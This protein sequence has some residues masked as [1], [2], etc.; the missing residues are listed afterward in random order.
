MTLS[1]QLSEDLTEHNIPIVPNIQYDI[2][3]MQYTFVGLHH[4]I[5]HAGASK[6]WKLIAYLSH[7][8]W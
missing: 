1:P 8:L 3:A 4:P 5:T 7:G 2:L 6:P